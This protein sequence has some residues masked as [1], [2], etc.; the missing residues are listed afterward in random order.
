MSQR[1]S[2]ETSVIF[3]ELWCSSLVENFSLT[4]LSLVN[5]KRDILSDIL[6]N[7]PFD[8]L[9]RFSAQVTWSM[10]GLTTSLITSTHTLTFARISWSEGALTYSYKTTTPLP[11]VPR[12]P[13][14]GW[15]TCPTSAGAD[16]T[17]THRTTTC[18]R[19]ARGPSTGP[20]QNTTVAWDFI[21]WM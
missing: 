21:E 3:I 4:D 1:I 18:G 2:F 14:T 6:V 19:H 12:T 9:S 15:P 8:I 17:A 20:H 13:R 10:Q 7:I 11:T 16:R 5:C